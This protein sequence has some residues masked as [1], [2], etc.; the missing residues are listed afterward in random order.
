ME[1][2]FTAVQFPVESRHCAYTAL[3][4]FRVEPPY[5]LLKSDQLTGLVYAYVAPSVST[6]DEVAELLES[7]RASCRWAR[8]QIPSQSS[9]VCKLR[10]R[11]S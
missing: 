3:V 5:V 7:A 10:R 6:P 4:P 9:S 1:S 11:L 8:A 2:L